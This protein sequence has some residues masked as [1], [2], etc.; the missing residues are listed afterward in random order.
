MRAGLVYADLYRMGAPGMTK[1]RLIQIL[2]VFEVIMV[3][4]LIV[5]SIR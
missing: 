2:V 5:M 3:I 1:R 4:A